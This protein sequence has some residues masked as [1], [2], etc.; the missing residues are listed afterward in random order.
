MARVNRLCAPTATNGDENFHYDVS[1]LMTS[2]SWRTYH[3]HCNNPPQ[4]VRLPCSL[5]MFLVNSMMDEYR[6]DSSVNTIS[7]GIAIERFF[8]ETSSQADYDAYITPK[9]SFHVGCKQYLLQK[10]SQ[11]YSLATMR[12]WIKKELL[13]FLTQKKPKDGKRR[14][15]VLMNQASKFQFLAKHN[16]FLLSET[17]LKKGDDSFL[18]LL[19]APNFYQTLLL[20]LLVKFKLS[21][22]V[23]NINQFK[24]HCQRNIPNFP[25]LGDLQKAM[26]PWTVNATVKLNNRSARLAWTIAEEDA[27]IEA[28]KVYKG[29]YTIMK[30]DPTYKDILANRS[31]HDLADKCRHIRFNLL[32]YVRVDPPKPPAAVTPK[33][34]SPDTITSLQKANKDLKFELE[35]VKKRLLLYETAI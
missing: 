15:V 16:A 2:H 20:R 23:L 22:K 9:V 32:K 35:A 30:K 29:L 6:E 21:D 24:P 14:K 1:L 27:L 13:H 10:L 4:Y 28:N 17:K 33:E 5:N 18:C 19:S 7:N 26:W 3:P 11:F 8:T 12:S 31:S 25:I 34:G